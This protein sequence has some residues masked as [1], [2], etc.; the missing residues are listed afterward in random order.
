MSQELIVRKKLV[1]KERKQ[2]GQV[3]LQFSNFPFLILW[4]GVLE[5]TGLRKI[6]DTR[7]NEAFMTSVCCLLLSSATSVTLILRLYANIDKA[8]ADRNIHGKKLNML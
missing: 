1:V 2:H 4:C 7:I 5:L 3:F 8:S 6:T